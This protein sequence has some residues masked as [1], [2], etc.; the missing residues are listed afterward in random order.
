MSVGGMSVISEDLPPGEMPGRG[1]GRPSSLESGALAEDALGGMR[2]SGLDTGL[3]ERLQ[4]EARAGRES[5][6]MA[7]G[8][9][10]RFSADG[11]E[12]DLGGSGG[13]HTAAGECPT[14]DAIRAQY[15]EHD[16]WVSSL[17][18]SAEAVLSTHQ[19]TPDA[20]PRAP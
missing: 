6:M 5:G 18:E 12:A 14:C 20:D 1:A 3:R 10:L 19:L 7:G 15:E 4:A 2:L 13:G 8:E 17:Q 9:S 11:S 16:A